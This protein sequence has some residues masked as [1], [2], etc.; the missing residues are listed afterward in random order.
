MITLDYRAIT[1]IG[2]N[3]DCWCGSKKKWKKCH[4]PQMPATDDVTSFEKKA[5]H[6]LR[7]WGIFLKTKEQIDGI[8]AASLMAAEILDL[9][10]ERAVEGVTTNTLDA[11]AYEEIV[12]R[13]AIPA[14]LHYGEPPFPKSICTSLNDVICHGIP[15][16]IPL[17]KGDILNIDLA[18]I[19][20]GF[21]GDCSKMVA[22]GPVSH[23]RKLVFDT[24]YDC[25][26]ESIK[27][28]K[29]NVPLN[30]IGEAI[31]RVAEARGCSVV[32]DFVGHGVGLRYHEQPQVYHY[33]TSCTTPLA[34]GMI[35]TIEPM[36]NA[37]SHSLYIEKENKWI[38]RTMDGKPSAQWEHTLLVTDDGVEIL[39]PWTKTEAFE[40]K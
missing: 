27:V 14:S 30:A 24:A 6:Y 32:T 9:V 31:E 8:R 17:E 29:P 25:L 13:G 40:L 33:Y 34:Q 2:R 4:F 10:S 38:A 11:F 28:I 39:T 16:D 20:N 36:I 23:D 37:G 1:M 35:F 26:M 18:V 12:R 5:R 22:V 19:Y 7:T 15:N 21:F 3:D